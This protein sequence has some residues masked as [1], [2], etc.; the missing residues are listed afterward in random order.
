LARKPTRELSAT[1]NGP[2]KAAINAADFISI[3]K[4]KAQQR[5]RSNDS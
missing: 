5:L 1:P 3:L 2:N 4:L